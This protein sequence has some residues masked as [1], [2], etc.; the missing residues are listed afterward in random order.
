MEEILSNLEGRCILAIPK[1]GRLHEKIIPLLEKM[2][3]QFVR[4]HRLDIALSTNH[5]NLAILFLPAADIPL[6]TSLG[7][8]DVGITGQDLIQESKAEVIELSRLGFGKCRLCVQAPKKAGIKDV[9]SL[10]GKRI[11]TS[12]PNLTEQFFKQLDPNTPTS[13]KSISGSVEIACA[14]GLADAIVDLVESGAT[15]KAAGLEI[16]DKIIDTEAVLIANPHTS[17]MNVIDMVKRRLLGVLTA[18]RYVMI[19]YNIERKNLQQAVEIT[20]GQKSPTLSPLEEN[21]WVAVKAMIKASEVNDIMD[22]LVNVGA[23]DI[24]V[25]QIH[26]CR[27]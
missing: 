12:F 9:K 5:A 17:H 4:Q 16:V 22:K 10:V 6:Y 1:K 15:M 2:D 20:P 14:L 13:I 26:N 7:R 25:T 27:I 3:I 24:F 11:I 19:E 21:Q 23:T 8:V 18:Q